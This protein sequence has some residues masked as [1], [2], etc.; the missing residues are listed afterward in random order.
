MVLRINNT[1]RINALQL[2]WV[3]CWVS[4]FIYRYADC[5]NFEC[6]YA[7]RCGAI[8]VC[9]GY[10]IAIIFL[11]SQYLFK[12]MHSIAMTGLNLNFSTDLFYANVSKNLIS[13]DSG[14][15]VS[16]PRLLRTRSEFWLKFV[17]NKLKFGLIT[18]RARCYKTVYVRNVWM[19]VISWSVCPCSMPF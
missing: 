12:I 8:F 11:Q 10:E 15:L 17:P 6:H 13:S 14:I 19:F 7:E 4:R 18:D 9:L 3:P 16:P 1:R 5:Q 2:N